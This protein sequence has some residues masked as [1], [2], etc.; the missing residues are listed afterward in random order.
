MTRFSVKNNLVL[1]GWE[2]AFK[3]IDGSTEAAA[4][5]EAQ[6]DWALNLDSFPVVD[7]KPKMDRTSP[8]YVGNSTRKPSYTYESQFKAGDGS[9]GNPFKNAR[10]LAAVLGVTSVTDNTTYTSVVLDGNGDS[11]ESFFAYFQH[12]S[13]RA[14]SINGMMCKELSIDAKENEFVSFDMGCLSARM[15]DMTGGQ[16]TVTSNKQSN[17]VDIDREPFHWKHVSTKLVDGDPSGTY[18]NLLYETGRAYQFIGVPASYTTTT[19][20]V[21]TDLHGIAAATYSIHIGVT[22]G[23]GDLLAVIV[24][25]AETYEDLVDEINSDLTVRDTGQDYLVR[26]VGGDLVVIATTDG[27]VTDGILLG[28]AASGT[29]LLDQFGDTG[30]TPETEST[31]DGAEVESCKVTITNNTEYKFGAPSSGGQTTANWYKEQLFEVS[32]ELTLYPSIVDD[33]LW[34]LGPE[35]TQYVDYSQWLINDSVGFEIKFTRSTN[36]F[37]LIRLT[38]LQIQEISEILENIESG[39]DPVTITL[40][41]AE[42]ASSLA[43]T[44]DDPLLHTVSPYRHN[45]AYG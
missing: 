23:G 3:K 19:P 13:K 39:V 43:V 36:D 21:P 7:L 4:S 37:V 44:A 24:G 18:S 35:K 34:S 38:K 16:I 42:S 27:A 31:S 14:K 11:R 20:I 40:N 2:G 45:L 15:F 29:S 6:L 22:G 8:W 26:F 28:D 17:L 9:L 32:V 30:A 41:M 5:L 12:G 1:F 33:I 10:V 25:A